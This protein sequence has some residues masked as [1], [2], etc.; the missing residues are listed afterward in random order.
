MQANF[1]TSGSKHGIAMDCPR[2]TVSFLCLG[3]MMKDTHGNMK[4][5]KGASETARNE[6]NTWH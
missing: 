3:V 5:L 4:G 2:K 1:I 6:K